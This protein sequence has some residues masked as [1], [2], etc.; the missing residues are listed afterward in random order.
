MSSPFK[1]LN[2]LFLHFN[3]VTLVITIVLLVLM[4]FL[5]QRLERIPLIGILAIL[6][7]LAN[8][9]HTFLSYSDICAMETVDCQFYIVD[10]TNLKEPILAELVEV[11]PPA[12]IMAVIILFEQFLYLEEF[13]RRGKRYR[14]EGTLGSVTTETKVLAVANIISGVLGGLPICINIFGTY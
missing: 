5:R 12:L 10:Q 7:I 6:G 2:L 13:E 9:G 14:N 11:L 1:I 4:F 8:W 3:V